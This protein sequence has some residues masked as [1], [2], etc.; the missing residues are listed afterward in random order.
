M[1]AMDYLHQRLQRDFGEKACDIEYEMDNRIRYLDEVLVHD[2][3]YELKFKAGVG[4]MSLQRRMRRDKES[5]EYRSLG[6]ASWIPDFLLQLL[7][8]HKITVSI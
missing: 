2:D 4:V 8:I 5:Y 3:G 6:I 7:C 1:T